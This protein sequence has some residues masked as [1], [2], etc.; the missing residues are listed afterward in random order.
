MGIKATPITKKVGSTVPAVKIGCQAGKACCLNL[1]SL[2]F[3][4]NHCTLVILEYMRNY[5][6]F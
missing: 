3:L 2:G 6:L 5:I 1:L 4:T